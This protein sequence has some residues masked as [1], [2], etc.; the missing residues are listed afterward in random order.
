MAH[1]QYLEDFLNYLKV[2]RHLSPHTVRNYRLD[3]SQFL[4]YW[5]RHQSGE[6]LELVTYRQVRPFL[7]QALKG[8]RRSTVARK[9]SSLRTFF[10]YLQRQGLVEVNPARLAPS[11]KLEKILPRFLSVDEAFHLLGSPEGEDAFQAQRDRAILC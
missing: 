1:W 10:K 6:T 5:E 4:D 3:L 9:L 8:R 11:P 7:A 2:E